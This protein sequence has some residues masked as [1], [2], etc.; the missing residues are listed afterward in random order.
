MEDYQSQHDEC[1]GPEFLDIRDLSFDQKADV[2]DYAVKAKTHH[3]WDVPHHDD[4]MA[5]VE[6]R[7]QQDLNA[8]VERFALNLEKLL[9]LDRHEKQDRDPKHFGMTKALKGW[10][11]KLAQY[12]KKGF[13]NLSYKEL[14]EIVDLAVDQAFPPNTLEALSERITTRNFFAG[15]VRD[16]I[17]HRPGD[18]DLLPT[19]KQEI[20]DVIN[21]AEK[22]LIDHDY[23]NTI[24]IIR[25]IGD[26]VR[27]D[28]KQILL[29]HRKRK[30][31]ASE[32]HQALFDEYADLN[33][34]MRRIAVTETNRAN[35]NALISGYIPGTKL[36]WFAWPKAC[37][38]C[39]EMDGRVVTVVDPGDPRG[40]EDWQNTIYVGKTNYGRAFSKRKMTPEGLVDRSPEE[41]AG[42]APPAHPHCRCTLVEVPDESGPTEPAPSRK[43][44]TDIL[45][46]N[47][48]KR[49]SF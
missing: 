42:P 23:H 47:R 9:G 44:M 21:E 43:K 35:M 18:A 17:D 34:D 13:E 48:A 41:L 26:D 25:G 37:P 33:K 49:K 28:M 2:V 16:M 6:D 1:C 15:K 7:N 36:K 29:D 5:E 3:K 22:D 32:L 11:R 20:P 45:R 31:G 8:L 19:T 39:R 46:E 38:H 12:R 14:M 10:A 24:G 40:Q 30:T 4:L 27:S